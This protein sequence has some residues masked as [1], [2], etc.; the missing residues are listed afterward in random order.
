[1]HSNRI[2]GII[3]RI[4]GDHLAALDGLEESIM[5]FSRQTRALI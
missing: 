2:V 1:M 3:E 5:E 4:I